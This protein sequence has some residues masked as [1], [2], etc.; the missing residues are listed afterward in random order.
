MNDIK[1]LAACGIPI[2]FPTSV[3]QIREMTMLYSF[4]MRDVFTK[5][6]NVIY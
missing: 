2:G 4:A 3:E 1:D 5:L 6:E